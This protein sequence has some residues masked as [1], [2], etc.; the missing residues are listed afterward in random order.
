MYAENWI[1]HQY[2]Y[3]AVLLFKVSAWSFNYAV[4]KIGLRIRHLIIGVFLSFIY[5]S[6]LSGQLCQVNC[7]RKHKYFEKSKAGFLQG[8]NCG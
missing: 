3:F 6:E 5:G 7:L 4:C 8:E 1:F 2:K